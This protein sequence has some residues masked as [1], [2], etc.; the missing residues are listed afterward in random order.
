TTVLWDRSTLEPVAPAIVWQDRRTADRCDALRETPEGRA[1][2]RKTGLVVDPYFSA[3]KLEWLLASDADIARRA[4]AGDL[5]F[6]TVDAW[7]IARL[8]G[9]RVHAT[10]PT[11]ASR[12]LLYDIEAGAW[13]AGLCELF[14]VPGA[15]LPEIRPSAGAFGV[16]DPDAIG[17]E[18]PITGVA[19]DQQAALFGQGCWDAGSAKNTYGTGAFLLLHTGAERGPE[20]DGVLTTVACGPTGERAFAYE[21]SILVAGAAIQ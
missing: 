11:N 13:D 1:I 6:G 18:A 5:A 7:L 10:D 15:I 19:G 20:V 17:L 14:G 21:G 16:S 4:A 2:R 12:T 3:T 8:T 9:G